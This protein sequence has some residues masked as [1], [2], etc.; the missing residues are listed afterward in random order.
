[1]QLQITNT[2]YELCCKIKEICW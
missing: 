2:I 1:M